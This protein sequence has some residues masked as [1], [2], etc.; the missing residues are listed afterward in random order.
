MRQ[1]HTLDRAD[2][3]IRPPADLDTTFVAGFSPVIHDCGDMTGTGN[4]VILA[5]EGRDAL[6]ADCLFY[7]TGRALDE[8]VDMFYDLGPGDAMFADTLTAD[9][10]NLQDAILGLPLAYTYEDNARGKTSVG[11]IHMIHGSKK[12]PVRISERF[13]VGS[14]SSPQVG[15]AVYPNPARARCNVACAIEQSGKVVLQVFDV[16]GRE[17]RTEQYEAE[18][19][20]FLFDLDLRGLPKGAYLLRLSGPRVLLNSSVIVQ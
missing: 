9:G 13:A 8:K 3:V 14:K 18:T 19:G 7:V 2:F 11:S 5:S 4:H 1:V 10:D 20:R 6:Y 17:L 16:L 12:I 15:L